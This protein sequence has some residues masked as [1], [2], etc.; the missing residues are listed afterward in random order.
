MPSFKQDENGYKGEV[1][2]RA[3]LSDSFWVLTR[4]VDADSV[5]L[6]VQ[7]KVAAASERIAN[8]NRAAELGYVQSKY[9]EKKNQVRIH[10][11]YVDDPAHLFRKGYFAFLHS[12]DDNE[13]HVHY[14]FTAEQIQE[15]W[16]VD[17]HDTYYCFSLTEERDYAPFRNLSRKRIRETISA[18]IRDLNGSI[19]ILIWRDVA[20][21]RA[22]TRLL[23]Y[24]LGTYILTR[25]HG[26]PVVLHRD[27]EHQVSPLEARKD[28]YPTRGFFEWGYDGTGPTLLAASLLA[29]FLG[30]D[31][32]TRG[33]IN[34][35]RDYLISR[36][37]RDNEVDHV[38]DTDMI[39]RAL[40]CIP[41]PVVDIEGFTELE[42][43][44][45][46]TRQ[47]YGKYL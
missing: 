19:E 30:G 27:D 12:D 2:S 36:L 31:L 23:G 6:I 21:R 16:Y 40:A 28:L 44:Y 1:R 5:D 32:P 24:P 45:A 11:S 47:K 8:R 29:H 43:L 39:L 38:I 9:F 42:A 25:P 10:K 26:C 37:E 13:E 3:L 33:Q 34:R 41:Y 4:S 20:A 7:E 18:G 15:A 46:E 35:L 22:D 17:E 14:F